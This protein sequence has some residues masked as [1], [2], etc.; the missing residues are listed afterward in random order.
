[1]ESHLSFGFPIIVVLL[2]A[3]QLA[4]YAGVLYLVVRIW[5]KVRHLPG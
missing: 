2:V 5:M 4:W 1:M 3:A